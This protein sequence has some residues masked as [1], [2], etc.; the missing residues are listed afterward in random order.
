MTTLSSHKPPRERALLA[1]TLGCVGII[2]LPLWQ[3][4]TVAD[5]SSWASWDVARW[6]RLLLGPEQIACYVC[7]LWAMLIM[8]GRGS[9]LRRQR[10]ALKM[11]LLPAESGYRILREDARPLQ[12][13]IDE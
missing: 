13:Q 3:T 1:L 10:R 11:D 6:G 9:E 7:F 5:S 12:R 8:A 2:C 4:F